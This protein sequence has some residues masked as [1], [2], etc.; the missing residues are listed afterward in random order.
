MEKKSLSGKLNKVVYSNIMF[1]GH[2]RDGDKLVYLYNA[3]KSQVPD[4]LPKES[5]DPF[6]IVGV[7]RMEFFMSAI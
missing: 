5:G 7:A 1:S 3:R 4:K 6:A 2:Q